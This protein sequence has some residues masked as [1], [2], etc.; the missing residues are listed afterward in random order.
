MPGGLKEMPA[1]GSILLQHLS[2]IYA[3]EFSYVILSN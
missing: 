2:H 3:N 1:S